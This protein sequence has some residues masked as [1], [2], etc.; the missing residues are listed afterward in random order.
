MAG[1]LLEK[2]SMAPQHSTD[3]EGA[4]KEFLNVDISDS[5]LKTKELEFQFSEYA[6]TC[7]NGS[8][9]Q[10]VPQQEQ[11][12]QHLL[13][14]KLQAATIEIMNWTLS[15]KLLIK[16]VRYFAM[17][18]PWWLLRILYWVKVYTPRNSSQSILP[19]NKSSLTVNNRRRI[20][21]CLSVSQLSLLL[22][23]YENDEYDVSQSRTSLLNTDDHIKIIQKPAKQLIVV[24]T[25]W[26]MFWR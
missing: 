4:W 26:M 14:P 21:F 5:D 17:L 13:Q 7:W 19:K 8:G 22:Y 2:I 9:K 3:L 16:K 18:K 15:W 1:E 20:I 12:Q 6:C 25:H 11:H 24:R 23:E 10:M